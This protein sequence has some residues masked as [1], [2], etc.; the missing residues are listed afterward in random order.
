[1]HL[2]TIAGLSVGSDVA[3][4]SLNAAGA[5]PRRPDVRIRRAAVPRALDGAEALGPNW[6]IAG[7]RFLLRVPNIARFLLTDGREIAF[8]AEPGVDAP[9]ISI[10]LLGT[11]FGIL[12]HQRRQIVLHASAVRVNGKAVLFCG[13]SGAGKSTLAA[14]L[15]Q[16]G[17]PVMTDDFCA[18]T[19]TQASIPMVHPGGRQLKLWAHTIER[20]QLKGRSGARVRSR[21]EKFYVDPGLTQADALPLG[22]LYALRQTQLPQAGAIERP[23]AAEAA[24]I[25]RRVA[26]RPRLV[27]RMGQRVDYFHAATAVAN[28]AGIFYLS[29]APDFAAMPRLIA[30]LERHWR[31]IGVA[32]QAA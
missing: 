22:A 1:M 26:Y 18:V 2:Y 32:E 31:D 8:E 30:Q 24:P 4:P 16:R 15:A 3:L 6:Q 21:S 25:L 14:A 12:L 7:R 17:Y 27:S 29:R 9:D 20:L 10:F 28:H 5:V 23:S 19:V 13:P 11:A